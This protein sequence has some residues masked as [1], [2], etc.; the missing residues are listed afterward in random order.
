MAKTSFNDL[1][2]TVLLLDS[3]YRRIDGFASTHDLSRTQRVAQSA[4]R[5]DGRASFAAIH[6][7]SPHAAALDGKQPLINLSLDDEE[8]GDD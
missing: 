4:L 6:D 8:S 1:R 5:L 3:N 2:Y 7:F